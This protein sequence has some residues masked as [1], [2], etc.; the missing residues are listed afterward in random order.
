MAWARAATT[1]PG[2]G[3]TERRA[4]A[5]MMGLGAPFRRAPPPCTPPCAHLV[6][7][8][9]A[10]FRN[11]V[12]ERNH[13]L[14]TLYSEGNNCSSHGTG[15]VRGSEWGKGSPR[16]SPCGFS[17]GPPIEL[18]ATV[19]CQHRSPMEEHP[20]GPTLGPLTC[21]MTCFAGF[22]HWETHLASPLGSCPGGARRDIS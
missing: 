14:P 20:L 4:G 1:L 22:R 10:R 3:E 18:A 19:G 15:R 6:S 12:S 16:A 17:A 11:C 8:Q 7:A 9:Y 2:G 21:T 13:L 5:K